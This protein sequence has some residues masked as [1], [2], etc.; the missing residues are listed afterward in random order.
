MGFF[1][2]SHLALAAGIAGQAA[3]A[4]ENARLF[5]QVKSE[6]EAFLALINAMPIP[7]LVIDAGGWVTLANQTAQESLLAPEAPFA[8]TSMAGGEGLKQALEKLREREDKHTEVQWPDQRVFNV[9]INQVTQLGT[10]IALDDITYLKTLDKM[11]TRFVETVS[12]DLKSPL[13]VIMGFAQLLQTEPNLTG[14]GQRCLQGIQ[15]SGQNMQALIN[16]LL[17]LAKIEAGMTGHIDRYDL[18]GWCGAYWPVLIC[19]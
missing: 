9:S 3:V 12:H 15:T 4:L 17:D 19:N 2:E 8:V 14:D 18:A 11:K 6:R 10:V 5:T 16:D 7:V 13:G 1:N